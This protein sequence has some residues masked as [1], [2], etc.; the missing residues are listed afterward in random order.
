M[1]PAYGRPACAFPDRSV[2]RAA[3]APARAGQ[4]I[5]DLGDDAEVHCRVPRSRSGDCAKVP[6]RR[7]IQYSHEG[8]SLRD[9]VVDDSSEAAFLSGLRL[10]WFFSGVSHQ[11]VQRLVGRNEV[12]F[13]LLPSSC[14]H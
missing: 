2:E 1:T 11:D 12:G 14:S 7:L 8:M 4:A 13:D 9:H 5:D 6:Q 3:P 10:L